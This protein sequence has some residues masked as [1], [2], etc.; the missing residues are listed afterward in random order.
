M[1]GLRI[2]AQRST[3]A[4]NTAWSL[5]SVRPMATYCVPWPGNIK[6]TLGGAPPT[7]RVVTRAGLPERRSAIASWLSRAT[8]VRRCAKAVRPTRSV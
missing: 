4:R 5:Y 3:T 2:S 7:A 6:A 1:S 8:K